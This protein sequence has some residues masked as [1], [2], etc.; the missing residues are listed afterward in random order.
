MGNIR[1]DISARRIIE[2]ILFL[3]QKIRVVGENAR[4]SSTKALPE[5]RR[6]DE[7]YGDRTEKGRLV[8]ISN[9]T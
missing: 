9:R 1:V 6:F 7:G 2:D 8:L 5:D 3:S 4:P